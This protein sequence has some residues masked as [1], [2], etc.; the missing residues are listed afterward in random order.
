M[1]RDRAACVASQAAVSR[2]DVR[3]SRRA[4]ALEGPAEQATAGARERWASGCTGTG[5]QQ[6]HEG[7]ARQ[8]V[9]GARQGAAGARRAC[10]RGAQVARSRSAGRAAWALGL[11]LGERAGYGLCTRCTRPVFD[12]V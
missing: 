7:R 4:W 2:H 8:G 12:P 9:A 5:G 11:G 6:R 3:S 1:A 10:G